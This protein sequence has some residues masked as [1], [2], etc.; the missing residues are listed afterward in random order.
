MTMPRLLPLACAVAAAVLLGNATLMP[1]ASV[2]GMV[3]RLSTTASCLMVHDGQTFIHP[4]PPL[5]TNARHRDN[6][7][8]SASYLDADDI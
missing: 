6:I 8:I 4:P 5:L 1:P 3:Q 2:R 7:D